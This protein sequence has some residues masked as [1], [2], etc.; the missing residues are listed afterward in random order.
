MKRIETE[1][2]E[3]CPDKKGMV[4]SVG[5]R[6]VKE[7]F[8]ELCEILNDAS[9]MP[10]ES[11]SLCSEF[12]HDGDVEFPNMSDLFCYAEWGTP[13][14]IYLIADMLIFDERSKKHNM[15][16]FI[17][18]KT[19]EVSEHAFD[20]MQYIAGYIYRLFMGNGVDH[21]RY[22]LIREGTQEKNLEYVVEKT[23]VEFTAWLKQK[24]YVGRGEPNDYAEELSKKAK[25]IYNI[26]NKRHCFEERELKELVGQENILDM[27]YQQGMTAEN[28][29]E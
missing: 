21:S 9:L 28:N 13:N 6:K 19:L 11:F 14:G 12:S 24:L 8:E 22:M 16:H 1:I 4:R 26:A 17:T 10:D 20:R 29:E 7:V 15:V 3:P 5:M 23:T 2:W 27:L 18:G 25:I